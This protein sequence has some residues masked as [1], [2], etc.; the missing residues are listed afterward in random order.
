MD[1]GDEESGDVGGQQVETG[2]VRGA[3]VATNDGCSG[4]MMIC[5]WRRH[6]RGHDR[7]QLGLDLGQ[8]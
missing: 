6:P 5:W 4:K 2:G 3:D 1:M 7:C 8:D